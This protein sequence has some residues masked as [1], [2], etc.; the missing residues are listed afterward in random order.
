[1]PIVP[2][3]PKGEGKR[4]HVEGR[5]QEANDSRETTSTVRVSV[6][7]CCFAIALG[8]LA[9]PALAQEISLRGIAWVGNTTFA[10]T[11][12]FEAVFD[13][14]SAVIYGAGG[15]LMLPGGVYVE[16]TTSWFKRDGER[17]SVGPNQ[18][19]LRLGIPL[20]IRIKPVEVTGGWRFR[21]WERFVPYGGAGYSSYGYRETGEFAGTP[22]NV[23]ERFSGYHIV[24]GAEFLPLRW[25]GIGG[26]VA[27]TS[28]ADALAG[29]VPVAFG[30]DN[31]GGTTLRLK[32]TL[33]R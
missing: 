21:K 1:M 27:W 18:Q 19:I 20:E 14:S 8:V 2:G 4:Q 31:L 30:E 29:R 12:S 25:L 3:G 24:G 10:A 7:T 11:D 9:T 22:E 16:L 23:E 26:E 15:Q 17:T 13:T 33:G 5:R 32:L 6:R 28:I